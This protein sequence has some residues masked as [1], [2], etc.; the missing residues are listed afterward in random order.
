MK[1]IIAIVG[2]LFLCVQAPVFAKDDFSH[3]FDYL[4]SV[5]PLQQGIGIQAESGGVWELKP[6][7]AQALLEVKRSSAGTFQ[8]SALTGTGGGLT[9]Q[10]TIVVNGENYSSFSVSLLGL[11]GPV[12]PGAS[13]VDFSGA[14]GASVLNNLVG[15][16]AKCDGVKWSMLIAANINIFN[17]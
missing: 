1:N 14:I 2:A 11:F 6:T 8:A 9:Y 10:R 7:A 5:R 17:N 12:F 4:F 3:P 15:V 13:S 16:Y